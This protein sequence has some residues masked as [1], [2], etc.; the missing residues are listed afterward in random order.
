M[1]DP[2][3]MVKI[4]GPLLT[5]LFFFFKCRSLLS[6]PTYLKCN[7]KLLEQPF[8]FPSDL[9]NIYV[10]GHSV[11]KTDSVAEHVTVPGM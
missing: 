2:V 1:Y 6:P 5:I 9:P 11:G 3:F 7:A 10:Y 4:S 8:S